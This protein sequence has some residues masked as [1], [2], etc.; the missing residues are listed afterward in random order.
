[1]V[2]RFLEQALLDSKT[3][4]NLAN[5]NCW[6]DD[7]FT[8]KL[9]RNLTLI[10]FNSLYSALIVQLYNKGL[11]PDS[12]E[13][14]IKKIKFFLENK[15]EI[16]KNDPKEYYDLKVFTNSYWGNILSRY[17]PKNA[18]YV[19][20]YL[21]AFYKELINNNPDN[22]VY[23]DVDSIFIQNM[24]QDIIDRVNELGISYDSNTIDYFYIISKKRLCYTDEN[25]F[26]KTRGISIKDKDKKRFLEGLIIEA[27]RNDRLLELGI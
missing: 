9:Y 23:A 21:N 25:N 14:Y 2:K 22:I 7:Y 5:N 6:L 17:N 15:D 4:T 20:D 10:D 13:D 16:K 26:I 19:T 11:M 12:D 1:M 18:H 24:N 27:R 8:N 3:P